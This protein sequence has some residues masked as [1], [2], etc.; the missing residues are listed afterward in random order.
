VSND[1]IL[2]KIP[3]KL[4][5][6]ISS[7]GVINRCSSARRSFGQCDRPGA[8]GSGGLFGRCWKVVFSPTSG[9]LTRWRCWA[10]LR[11]H[12]CGGREPR[13]HPHPPLERQVLALACYGPSRKA[14][15]CAPEGVPLPA[16][17][18]P[19]WYRA[20]CDGCR[21]GDGQPAVTCD[22]GQLAAPPYA[23]MAK[24]SAPV[25]C[26]PSSRTTPSSGTFPYPSP[27]RT[28]P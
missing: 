8:F 1:D 26:R 14:G 13:H 4:V 28:P 19:A 12:L 18:S 7:R 25:S 10:C 24:F 2:A 9:V 22:A 21:R 16:R 11:R 3:A 27:G 6:Q 20:R 15:R 5:S 23:A 17:H